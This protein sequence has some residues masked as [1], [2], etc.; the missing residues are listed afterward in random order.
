MRTTSSADCGTSIDHFLK[1]DPFFRVCSRNRPDLPERRGDCHIKPPPLTQAGPSCRFNLDVQP[2]PVWLGPKAALLALFL[3]LHLAARA[4]GQTNLVP[5][6][7]N[8]LPGQTNQ[9]PEPTNQVLLLAA[10]RN[11]PAGMKFNFAPSREKLQSQRNMERGYYLVSVRI[12]KNRLFPLTRPPLLFANAWGWVKGDPAEYMVK[13]FR[14]LGLNCVATLEDREKPG[15]YEKLYGWGSQGAHYQPPDILPHDAAKTFQA[16][17]QHYRDYFT[18]GEGKQRY[19]SPGMVSFQM[20]DEPREIV[21]KGGAE[22]QAGFREWLAGQ[23]LKPG[24]F[25]KHEW[26]DVALHLGVAK[27]PEEQRLFYWSRRYQGMLTPKMF[28][29][30]CDAFCQEAPSRTVKPFVALSGHE[31]YLWGNHMPLDMF[32]LAQYPN[33]TPGISD[34]MKEAPHAWCWDTHQAVAFSVAAYNG[35]ARR[36]GADFGQPPISFP[37]MHCVYP[38]L[39][40]AY[41]QLANQCKLISYYNYGP[42]YTG[43]DGGWSGRETCRYAVHRINNQAAQMDDILGPATLRPS[44]VAMLYAMSTEYRKPQVSF[45]DKRAT[46]LALSHEYFQPELVNEDQIAAGALQHYAALYVLDPWITEAAQQAIAG[47]VQGGGLLWACADAAAKNEYDEPCD[48]LARLGLKREPAATNL[49]GDALLVAPVKDQTQFD[50]HKTPAAGRPLAIACPGALVRATY[51]DG[52]PA[53]LECGVQKGKLVYVGHR[54]GLVYSM[55]KAKWKDEALWPWAGER[56]VI[57]Q[58]LRE[59]DIPRELIIAGGTNGPLPQG[60]PIKEADVSEGA[61]V[62]DHLVLALPLSTANGTVIPIFN[63]HRSDPHP[64]LNLV[65]K[66][67]EPQPPLSVQ[68]IVADELKLADLPFEH[69]DGWLTTTLPYLPDDGTLLLVRRTPAPPDDRIGKIRQSTEEHLASDDWQT[70]SAGA[71]FAGFFPEWKLGPKLEPLLKHDCWAVRRSAA[72][73]LGRLGVPAAGKAVRQALDRETDAHAVADEIAAL[74]LL[75]HRDAPD[76]CRALQG[77][78]DPFW[79]AEGA[80]IEKLLDKR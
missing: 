20:R 80:R 5:S 41:T 24:F 34:W 49:T 10:D 31:F 52:V 71:W 25:G 42:G 61:L 1:T 68:W 50:T 17:V 59:A 7:T 30:A 21:L 39:F 73:A 63:M 44:R 16:Y 26:Q 3:L 8:K 13:S 48:L 33:M 19:S 76:L 6:Q 70:L 32:Q 56:N 18:T 79:Q 75:G 45:T 38:S 53:W 36:Y 72:E 22:D 28:G 15:K 64:R 55:R 4:P 2:G 69:Q 23:G 54:A 60:S 66:L 14:L 78:P 51:G 43:A 40:R 67:R 29:L 9:A 74:A 27:M 58:S 35:G 47:W 37:M 46:F 57:N 11:Q 77:N 12:A 65:V 62:S